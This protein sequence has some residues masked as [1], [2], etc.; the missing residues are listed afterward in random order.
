M[1]RGD[2]IAL[3]AQVIEVKERSFTDNKLWRQVVPGE[4][5]RPHVTIALVNVGCQDI[6]D[7]HIK[8]LDGHEVIRRTSDML[9]VIVR[10]SVPHIGDTLRFSLSYSS[11]VAAITSP[12]VIK[13]YCGARLSV[14]AGSA[15]VAV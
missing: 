15:S 9:M 3:R 2:G 4:I 6:G 11:L 5:E 14:G 13:R 7:G 10:G 12:Y 1:L 8:S